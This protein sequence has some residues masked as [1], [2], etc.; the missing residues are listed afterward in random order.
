MRR[1]SRRTNQITVPGGAA[2]PLA[3]SPIFAALI[4]AA[5]RAKDEGVDS[6]YSPLTQHQTHHLS[7]F[8]SGLCVC[9]CVR[10]CV[11]V[12]AR[13]RAC[14]CVRDYAYVR[15]RNRP[16]NRLQKTSTWTPTARKK[17]P[18][19]NLREGS[20]VQTSL[21]RLMSPISR[22]V[23]TGACVRVCVYVHVYVHVYF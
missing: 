15:L 2:D 14:V 13:A 7:L 16:L 11:C 10:A 19:T 6:T 5:S 17:R 8:E 20:A 18:H 1:T 21:L 23:C 22:S 3:S 4:H 9:V 12:C